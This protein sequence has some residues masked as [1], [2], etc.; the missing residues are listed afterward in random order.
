M[1]L[2][3]TFHSAQALNLLSIHAQ[4]LCALQSVKACFQ[5]ITSD[6]GHDCYAKHRMLVL[7][8]CTSSDVCTLQVTK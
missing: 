3:V 4:A 7:I 8:C 2:A 5:K 1:Q 6:E